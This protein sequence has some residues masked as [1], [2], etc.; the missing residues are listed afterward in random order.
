MVAI[1]QQT[2][3]LKEEE[4]AKVEISEP[5]PTPPSPPSLESFD[6]VIVGG[7]PA[8]AYAALARNVFTSNVALSYVL[9]A[10]NGPCLI[11]CSSNSSDPRINSRYNTPHDQMSAA[12]PL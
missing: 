3:P 4:E 6:L 9:F 7:G 10:S 11:Q 1:E 5:S 2:P 12:A 8:G